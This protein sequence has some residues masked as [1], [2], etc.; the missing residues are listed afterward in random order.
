MEKRTVRIYK[1]PDGQGRYINKT[2]KFLN[3]AQEGA[4]M[5][6]GMDQYVQYI[7]SELQNQTDPQEIYQNLVEAGLP[8]EN[9][10]DLIQQIMQSMSQPQE[11]EAPEYQDGGEQQVMDQYAAMTDEGQED[12]E[13]YSVDEMVENTPGTQTFKFPGLDQYIPSYNPIGWDE[14]NVDAYGNATFERGG[15]KKS[16]AKN[17]LSYLKKQQEGGEGD[18]AEV[19]PNQPLGRGNLQDTSTDTVSK[20]KSDFLATLKNQADTAKTEELHG[21]MMQSGDPSLMQIANTLGQGEKAKPIP[22]PPIAQT[23]GF[24]GGEDSMD[25]FQD[26]GYDEQYAQDGTEVRR[27]KINYVPRYTTVDGGLR[28]LIP[29]N[30]LVTSKDKVDVSNAYNVGDKSAY[31]GGLEG[32]KPIERRV[33]KTEIFGRPKEW[34]D[35]YS[36]A[37]QVDPYSGNKLLIGKYPPPNE[38]NSKGQDWQTITGSEH[39]GMSDD[40]WD[41]LSFSAKRAIKKGD[42]E[43]VRNERRYNKQLQKDK[44]FEAFGK[45][46]PS[47]NYEFDNEED[48]NTHW[49]GLKMDENMNPIPYKLKGNVY[50]SDQLYKNAGIEYKPIEFNADY[51][52]EDKWHVGRTK[53]YEAGGYLPKAQTGPTVKSGTSALNPGSDPTNPANEKE[54]LTKFTLDLDK[55]E[56][57]ADQ[58]GFWDQAPP[59]E[60]PEYN[61]IGIDSKRKKKYGFNG[62][63]GV[64]VFN[65]GAEGVLG[66][67]NRRQ[68]QKQQND[69]MNNNFNADNIY[70]HSS[71]KDR[72]DYVD[73]GSQLGQFRFD[74]MGSNTNGRFAYG[75]SGGYMESGGYA[76]GDELDMDEDQIKEFLANGGEVEYL[77]S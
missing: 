16:F 13:S 7:Q 52:P 39:A 36:N 24:T 54:D 44:E 58:K 10:Q 30:R 65:A 47:K 8:E 75:Q 26:G 66:F 70:A 53:R 63:E 28:N 20:R 41:K 15:T 77:E 6:S 27:A 59:K 51:S 14:S 23:G 60:T 11:G 1:A 34:T 43:A 17:V 32:Y 5:D 73:Y 68:Q 42:R 55:V 67:I 71:D 56:A 3:K 48:Y 12:P 57:E 2:S 21:K 40:D 46:L 74:E 69:F 50:K 25:Y 76:E 18:A 62:E 35:I 72:G 33:T 45:G 61:T 49:N 31:T 38:K 29:W 19:D 9:A 4:Q 22:L 64:N 37:P